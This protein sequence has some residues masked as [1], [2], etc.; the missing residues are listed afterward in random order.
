MTM[1]NNACV[2]IPN[3]DGLPFV[4]DCLGTLKKQTYKHDVVVVDNGSVDG[5]IDAISKKFPEVHIIALPKNTGFTGGVNTGLRYAL[6]NGYEYAA[7]LNNDALPDKDWLKQLVATMEEDPKNGSMWCSHRLWY[8]IS[9]TLTS[10]GPS[11]GK[12]P[13]PIASSRVRA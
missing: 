1:E 9:R 6:E 7:L 10:P 13:C 11:A 4:L 12:T 8:S 2:I 3:W 5:S